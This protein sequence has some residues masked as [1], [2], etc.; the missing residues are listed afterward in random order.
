MSFSDLP[1]SIREKAYQMMFDHDT[2]TTPLI[3]RLREFND[4]HAGVAAFLDDCQEKGI[5]IDGIDVVPEHWRTRKVV[6]FLLWTAGKC[7]ESKLNFCFRGPL[8]PSS[9]TLIVTIKRGDK[10]HNTWEAYL[11]IDENNDFAKQLVEKAISTHFRA[12]GPQKSPP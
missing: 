9:E 12:G 5:V 2:C 8:P 6:E 1:E 3:R 11:C 4:N 7:R 10:V